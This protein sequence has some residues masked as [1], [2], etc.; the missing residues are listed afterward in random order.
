MFVPLVC[1]ADILYKDES[2]YHEFTM[3]GIIEKIPLRAI[4]VCTIFSNA[5]LHFY[6]PATAVAN[7][8][9]AWDVTCTVSESSVSENMH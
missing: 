7:L 6:R 3:R 9:D 4:D 1:E 2:R 8:P 5:R